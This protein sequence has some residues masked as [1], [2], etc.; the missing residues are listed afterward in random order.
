MT[1]SLL[2]MIGEKAE[3]QWK[4]FAPCPYDPI[5]L[6][7]MTK[8]RCE[9]CQE[10]FES[11]KQALTEIAV[12]AL[13][14]AKEAVCADGMHLHAADGSPVRGATGHFIE[15]NDSKRKIDTLL[16]TLPL[17][18]EQREGTQSEKGTL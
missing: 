14:E 2:E 9:G 16:R 4:T 18:P 6:P 10:C 17:N 7:T 13:M 11:L 3:A 8:S 12:A 5:Y 15:C 1:L